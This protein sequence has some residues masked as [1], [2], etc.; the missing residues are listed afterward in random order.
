[1]EPKIIQRIPKLGGGAKDY[2]DY[3]ITNHNDSSLFRKYLHDIRNMKTLDKELINNIRSMSNEEKMEII[4]AFND[5]VESIKKY[6][7]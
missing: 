7:E 5:V 4:I 1:M 6:I 2:K 3:K